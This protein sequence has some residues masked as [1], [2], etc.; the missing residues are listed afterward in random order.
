MF[1]LPPDGRLR[2][3]CAKARRIG[4]FEN[5]AAKTFLGFTGVSVG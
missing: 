3:F 2:K 5:Y 1:A 4:T